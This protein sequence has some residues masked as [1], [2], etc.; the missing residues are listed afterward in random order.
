LTSPATAPLPFKPPAPAVLLLRRIMALALRHIYLH[1]GSWPRI[2][3]MMYWPLVNLSGWGFTSLYLTKKF[4]NAEA[5]GSTMIAGVVLVE[6]FLRPSVTALMMFMEELWSRNLGHLFASPIQVCEYALGLITVALL[7]TALAL[8]PFFIVAYY[9]FGFSPLSLGWPML[10][11]ASLLLLN[12]CIYGLM[13]VTVILRYG[14]A[15]EW[16]AWM[17]TWLLIPFFA[18]YYPL[19]ILPYGFQVVAHALPPT[20][21]LE[22]MKSLIGEGELH[23]EN[24]VTALGLTVVYGFIA[25]FVFW[26]AYQSARRRGGLLQ[27]GE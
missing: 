17:A 8:I 22:S 16:L 21:V 20:Y 5:L 7:R 4:A 12:G 2:V 9:L 3:E 10:T 14:L 24:L 13:I 11:F 6:F 26:R 25:A 27:S 18:P 15:A 1:L 19:S 23:P